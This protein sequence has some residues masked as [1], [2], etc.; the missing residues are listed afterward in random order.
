MSAQTS[1]QCLVCGA[2]M[3][4]VM[5]EPDHR[6][7]MHSFQYRTYRCGSCGDTERRFVFDPTPHAQPTTPVATAPESSIHAQTASDLGEVLSEEGETQSKIA[8]I[9]DALSVP[10]AKLFIK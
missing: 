5:I 10:F 7:D 3:R 6:V 8:R 9:A 1:M 4:A 2:E